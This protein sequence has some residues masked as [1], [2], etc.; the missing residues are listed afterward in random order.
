MSN[1]NLTIHGSGSAHFHE[2]MFWKDGMYKASVQEAINF[3]SDRAN[4]TMEE[5]GVTYFFFKD[6]TYL[7]L[8]H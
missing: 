7:S 3:L 5:S 1:I 6:Q 4:E 8:R 2:G